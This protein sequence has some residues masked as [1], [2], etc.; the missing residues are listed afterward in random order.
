[1]SHRGMGGSGVRLGPTPGESDILVR[2]AM[3]KGGT[4]GAL[5]PVIRPVSESQGDGPSALGLPIQC[6]QAAGS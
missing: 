5:G 3:T 1:M 2:A 6:P 4:A